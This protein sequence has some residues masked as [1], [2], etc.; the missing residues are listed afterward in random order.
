[1]EKHK[2]LNNNN[3]FKISAPIWND[4]FELPNRSYSTSDIQE[5]FECILKR[6]NENIVDSSIRIYKNKIENIITFRIKTGYYL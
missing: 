2:N 6:Y 4:K 3:K 5:Y 1:M